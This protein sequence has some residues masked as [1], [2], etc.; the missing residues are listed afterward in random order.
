MEFQKK[1]FF[2]VIFLGQLLKGYIIRSMNHL[3]TPNNKKILLFEKRLFLNEDIVLGR[4]NQE[5]E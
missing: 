1:H 3:H 2:L 5:K 4:K